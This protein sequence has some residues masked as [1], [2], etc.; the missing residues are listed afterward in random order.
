MCWVYEVA[1]QKIP[2][3]STDLLLLLGS[4]FPSGLTDKGGP[5]SY[6]YLMTD[7]ARQAYVMVP[8][9]E[10]VLVLA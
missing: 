10:H 5:R 8:T 9:A 2:D 3:L 1:V 4:Q 6:W 7:G